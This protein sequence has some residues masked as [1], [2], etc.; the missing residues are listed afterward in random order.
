MVVNC[1]VERPGVAIERRGLRGRGQH[2]AASYDGGPD[3]TVAKEIGV[4]DMT[5]GR[6]R[7][8]TVT[9][10][11]VDKR[12]GLDGKAYHPPYRARRA[13]GLRAA[14]AGCGRMERTPTGTFR[15]E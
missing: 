7:K 3:R 10:I 5:V 12:V 15:W 6:A 8:A 2:R 14:A 13:M 1:T 4:S 9:N 11:A